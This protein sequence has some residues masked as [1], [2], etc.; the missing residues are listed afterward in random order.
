MVSAVFGR[1]RKQYE[2]TTTAIDDNKIT[3]AID[4]ASGIVSIVPISNPHSSG[5]SADDE[6][7]HAWTPAVSLLAS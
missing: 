3:T 6:V 2:L 1:L 7:G 5:T 4:K